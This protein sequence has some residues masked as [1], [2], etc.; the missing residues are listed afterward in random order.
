MARTAKSSWKRT[1]GSKACEHCGEERVAGTL[2]QWQELNRAHPLPG[3]FSMLFAL[4][5][6]YGNDTVILCCLTCFCFQPVGFVGA[7]GH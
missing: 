6:E 4:E 7:H 1:G 3:V 2:V 5:R